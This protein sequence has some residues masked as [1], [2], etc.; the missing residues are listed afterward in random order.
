MRTIDWLIDLIDW[1]IDWLT[2]WLIAALD[3]DSQGWWERRTGN[4]QCGHMT[5]YGQSEHSYFVCFGPSFSSPQ[6]RQ[7]VSQYVCVR[8]RVLLKI[9]LDVWQHLCE[10]YGHHSEQL[11]IFLLTFYLIIFTKFVL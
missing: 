5:L 7:P 2:D 6:Q 8:A 11:C 10:R 4:Q 9:K 1:L 3:E